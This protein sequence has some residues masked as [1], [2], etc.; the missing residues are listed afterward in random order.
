MAY[1]GVA[2]WLY[3][4]GVFDADFIMVKIGDFAL[5]AATTTDF[6]VFNFCG[7]KVAV[8]VFGAF[9]NEFAIAIE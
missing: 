8:N 3:I 5:F 7:G 6:E 2:I 4:I 9:I 1:L